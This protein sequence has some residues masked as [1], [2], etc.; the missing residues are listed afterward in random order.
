[1]VPITAKTPAINRGSPTRKALASKF[2]LNAIIDIRAIR[3]RT[4]LINAILKDLEIRKFDFFNS[5]Q[6]LVYGQ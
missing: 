1:M 2:F 6:R 4:K 5:L 3:S